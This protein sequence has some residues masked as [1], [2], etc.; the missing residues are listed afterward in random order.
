MKKTAIVLTALL[1]FACSV[2]AFAAK[3][4][5][6]FLDKVN[7]ATGTKIFATESTEKNT[8]AE[9]Q[10]KK[11]EKVTSMDLVLIL[12]KSGSMYGLEKDT[13]GGFNSMLDKQRESNLPV[14]VTA[15]M[16]NNAV[17]TIYERTDLNEVKNI[18]DKEYTPQGTTALLDAVGN[19]LSQMKTLPDIDAKG[20][21]VLV[22]I[23]TDGKENAS[24]E[25]TYAK[26]KTL[27]SELQEKNFEFV[28]LGAN[29]DAA[30]TAETIG[31]RKENAVKYKNTK[32]GVQANFRAVNAMVEDYARTGSMK[33][34]NWKKEVEEDK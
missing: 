10:Q 25:W 18:T 23:T 1:A 17:S 6:T 16:F 2:T 9:Q 12:D 21:K 14:K 31:I 32:S 3:S 20:N 30:Q 7:D 19:T 11:T 29:I 13:I 26:V 28:F 4:D 5:N 34:E 33:S 22:V 24:K 27:I 15:V 8:P